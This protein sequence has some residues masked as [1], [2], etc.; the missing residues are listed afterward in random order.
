MPPTSPPPHPCSEPCHLKLQLTVACYWKSPWFSK[1]IRANYH[2]WDLKKHKDPRTI[3]CT[4]T[5]VQQAWARSEVCVSHQLLDGTAVAAGLNWL[6][7][8]PTKVLQ[9][10][11]RASRAF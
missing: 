9:M 7:P 8:S 2:L 3:P 5:V 4:Q 11:T 6:K 10:V 1:A